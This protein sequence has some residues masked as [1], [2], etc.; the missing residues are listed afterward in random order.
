MYERQDCEVPSACRPASALG[1]PE[2]KWEATIRDLSVGGARLVLRRRFEAGTALAIE[3]PGP[4][5]PYT[6]L[7][8]VVY[9]RRLESG[10]W[11]LGC[12]FISALSETEQER[13]LSWGQAGK[14]AATVQDV[15]LRLLGP[16][17]TLLECRVRQFQPVAGWPLPPGQVLDLKGGTNGSRW[18]VTV[19]VI[20]CVQANGT[21]RLTCRLAKNPT[22]GQLLGALGQA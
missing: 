8:K 15:R 17:G 12:R 21:W 7:A 18:K 2:S 9:V 6:V 14:R 20:E 1:D 3:L 16:H 19:R 13:L 11:S 5:D 22:A 4:D 10:E